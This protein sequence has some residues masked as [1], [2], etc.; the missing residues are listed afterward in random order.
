MTLSPERQE[1][2]KIFK[3]HIDEAVVELGEG[4]EVTIQGEFARSPIRIA[5]E[6]NAK[7]DIP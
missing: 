3:K 5:I 7:Q 6:I 4:Y 1:I 2:A